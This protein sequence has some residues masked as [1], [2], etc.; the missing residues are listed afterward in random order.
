MRTMKT[1][2]VSERKNENTTKTTTK[3]KRG[4]CFFRVNELNYTSHMP[5]RKGA[6]L[7]QLHRRSN[8][9]K[10]HTHTHDD[11]TPTTTQPPPHFAEGRIL[12]LRRLRTVLRLVILFI[13]VLF[14]VHILVIVIVL[15]LILLDQVVSQKG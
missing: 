12:R 11:A 15:I 14:V 8:E 10:K 3:K 1:I 7:A 5:I 4:V 9:H 6:H 13:L 2:H